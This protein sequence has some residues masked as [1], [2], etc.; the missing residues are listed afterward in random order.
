MFPLRAARRI[1]FVVRATPIG[2]LSK[3]WLIE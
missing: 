3:E 2:G 1:D